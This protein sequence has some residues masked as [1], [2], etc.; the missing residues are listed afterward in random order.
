MPKQGNLPKNVSEFF[1]KRLG[2]WRL[3]YRAK[4]QQTHYFK[5]K[6]GT[7]GFEAELCKCR[8]GELA[9]KPRTA[10]RTKP[11]SMSALIAVYYETSDFLSLAASTKTTYRGIIER[12]RVK[13]G[14][15]LVTELS[16]QNVRTILSRMKDRP[17]AANKLLERLKVLLDLAVDEGWRPDNPAARIK[18]YRIRSEG[19]H[20]WSEDEI[21][22][23]EERHAAGTTARRALYLLLYLGQRRSDVPGL[24]RQH[25][26]G[27]D[28]SVAQQK[29]RAR[30]TIPLHPD[31]AAELALTPRD[32]MTFLVTEYGKP[33]SVAGFGNKMRQWCDQAQLPVCSAHGL[34]KAAARRLAEAGCSNQDIK[35]ITGHKTDK[36]VSHYTAAADQKRRARRAALHLGRPE[37][38]QKNG[39]L[40][41]Q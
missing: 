9:A 5:E 17:N 26:S 12:F 16:R 31:L 24:G 7:P 13:Y 15:Q 2:R 3:R 39:S 29:T 23:Y 30:L 8:A 40:G 34:R 36:E 1:D 38:E 33:F 14:H 19:F 20:T 25:L 41:G 27:N 32:Q 6:F 10:M 11:G 37:P 21:A 28:I 22:Q 4:G 18:P 35:S